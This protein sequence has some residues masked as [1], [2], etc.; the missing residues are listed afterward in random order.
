MEG[1]LEGPVVLI[2]LATIFAALG[3][4]KVA[5]RW[6]RE[7]GMRRHASQQGW[8]SVGE[9]DALGTPSPTCSRRSGRRPS[10]R[11]VPLGVPAVVTGVGR[12]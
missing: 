7:S 1:L 5:T 2:V 3:L 8:R 10:R 4:A 12:G 9:S 6:R 11:R